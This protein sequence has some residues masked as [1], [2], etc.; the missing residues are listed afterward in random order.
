ML[1]LST[2]DGF[3]DNLTSKLR[4]RSTEFKIVLLILLNFFGGNCPLMFAEVEQSGALIELIIF[5]RKS[6][7][8]TLNAI[9]FS[10]LERCN[11]SSLQLGYIIVGGFKRSVL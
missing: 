10:V 1:I 2:V 3:P 8:V 5:F 7:G 4:I 9:S 11:S 6:I